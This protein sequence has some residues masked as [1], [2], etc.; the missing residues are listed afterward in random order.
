MI[1]GVFLLGRLVAGYRQHAAESA[2]LLVVT[3]RE[4]EQAQRLAVA[5]ER[6]RIAR[7]LHDVVSHD[8]SLMVLQ[9]SV[10]L[11]LREQ[12]GSGAAGSEVLAAIER[13]GRDALAELRRMLGVLRDDDRLAPLEPQ[14]GLAQL[15]ELLAGAR[16]A[17]VDV[18]LEQVGDLTGLP[19]GLDLAAYRVVQESL[20]NITKHVGP[21]HVR[22]ALREQAGVLVIE[23]VDDGAPA[24]GLP[25]REGDLSGGHG[26]VGMRERV[27]LYGGT[28]SA[29]PY[30]SGFRV[31]ARLPIVEP[32]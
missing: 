23:V 18:Q 22:L 29:V 3:R 20:T 25:H 30:G 31:L 2:E 8:V 12:S 21:T 4:A 19:S 9:A 27:G 17:G 1:I 28:V 10:E 5:Q 7:E 15:D 24:A 14:P 32:V 16:A 6:T 13:T 26:L 11:R